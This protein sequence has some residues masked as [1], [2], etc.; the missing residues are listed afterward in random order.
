MKKLTWSDPF[1][2]IMTSS[3]DPYLEVM[4]SSSDPFLEVMTS[5][6]DFYC[7]YYCYRCVIF[8]KNY[9]EFMCLEIEV[10]KI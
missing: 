10:V 3:S 8:S 1:L 9:R 7:C 5:S 6:S 4:T 2:E